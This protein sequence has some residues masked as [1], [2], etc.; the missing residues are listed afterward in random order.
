M[1]DAFALADAQPNERIEGLFMIQNAQLG[2]TRSGKP[3]LRCLLR[4]A[5][6][7]VAARMWNANEALVGTLP[8]DGFVRLTGQTQNYQGQIQIIIDSIEGADPSEAELA[9]LLPSTDRDV[10]AMFTELSAKLE[11]LEHRPLRRLAE[12]Y[13]ND[14]PLMARFRQAP[15]AMRLHHARLGGLL[16]HTLTLMNLAERICDLYP[17]LNRDLVMVGLFLHD[18]G[19]CEELHWEKG[20]GYSEDGQL[21]GHVAR[22]MLWLEEKARQ[23]AEAG[24]PVPDR[25]LRAVHHIILSHHGRP[26]Y[27]ALKIP[28]TPEAIAVSHIDDLDAKLEMA[29]VAA[30]RQ[31]LGPGDGAF[32]EKQWPLETRIFRPDPTAEAG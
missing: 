30:D 27:G 25:L 22:G 5:S 24:E 17:H 26:E 18:L 8:T 7:E 12:A 1:T 14:A 4:D 10:D 11:A 16:E 29:L 9:R 23:I 21:V 2:Q 19:K 15:A 31:N 20:F 6:A 32:T 13:L 3:Y 28:A